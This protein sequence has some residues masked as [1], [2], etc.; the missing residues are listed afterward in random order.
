MTLKSPLHSFRSPWDKSY[1]PGVRL[2]DLQDFCDA[3]VAPAIHDAWVIVTNEGLTV[4]DWL[5]AATLSLI[6]KGLP[7]GRVAY[8][9]K[10]LHYYRWRTVKRLHSDGNCSR[11]V[12]A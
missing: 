11:P 8:R 9:R 2:K 5:A 7:K 12:S 3:G 4:P 1:D 10:M 6:A